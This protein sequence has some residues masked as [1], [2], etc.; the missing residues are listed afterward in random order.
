[1]GNP[2]SMNHFDRNLGNRMKLNS[3]L[4]VLV[5]TSAASADFTIGVIPDVQYLSQSE[6]G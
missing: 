4:Y 5:L 1:M 2:G 3:V 6:N